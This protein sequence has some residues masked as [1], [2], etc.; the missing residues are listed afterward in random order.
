MLRA[1]IFDFDGTILDTETPEFASWADVYAEF[2]H[3]LPR[4]RYLEAVGRGYDPALFEPGAHL[5]GLLGGVHEKEALKN[6]QRASF[7]RRIASETLRP[8]VAEW[9]A[10]AKRLGWGRAIASSSPRVWLE[11]HLPRLGLSEE[12][13]AV[14]TRDDVGEGRTKPHPDLFL[15]ACARLEVAPGQAVVVEDSENG[16]KA[17]RAAGCVTVAVPNPMTAAM[18]FSLAD[19]FF[20][21]L[22]ECKLQELLSS[23]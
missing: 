18:D 2:Q 19:Y 14:V 20:Q 9:L 13:D 12:F 16:V 3:A 22:E 6:L 4:D 7:A 5:H 15:A 11:R 8:G 17:A 21:S 1:L 10:G 23:S